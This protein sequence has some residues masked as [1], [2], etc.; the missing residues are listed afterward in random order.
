MEAIPPR[1]H[2]GCVQ[3]LQDKSRRFDNPQPRYALQAKYA[4]PSI[5]QPWSI[6]MH[7]P[8]E[9]VLLTELIEHPRI[10]EENFDLFLA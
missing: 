2:H 8:C 3:I 10:K 9:S 6:Y 7:R 5:E 4:A 1:L